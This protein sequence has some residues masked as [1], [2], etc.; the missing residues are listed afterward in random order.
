MTTRKS[1]AA[2]AARQC[3]REVSKAK[4]AALRRRRTIIRATVVSGVLVLVAVVVM[5]RALREVTR[6]PRPNRPSR[7]ETPRRFRSA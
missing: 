6:S 2:S 4:A 3:E 7:S 5:S 1:T